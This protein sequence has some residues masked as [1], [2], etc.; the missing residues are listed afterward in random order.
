[1]KEKGLGGIRGVRTGGFTPAG[2]RS[3]GHIVTLGL[4]AAPRDAH[5]E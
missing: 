5:P 4:E 1:M 3:A 2:I